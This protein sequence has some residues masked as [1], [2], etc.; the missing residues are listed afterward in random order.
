MAGNCA[1]ARF[2]VTWAGWLMPT[3]AVVTPRRAAAELQRKLG[4][5]REVTQLAAQSVGARALNL[6]LEER[7]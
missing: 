4:I 1:A 5:G 2:S 6:P 3:S 7:C